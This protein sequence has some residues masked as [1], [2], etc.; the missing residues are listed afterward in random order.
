MHA[1]LAI[2]DVTLQRGPYSKPSPPAK[3]AFNDAH[4]IEHSCAT[5][6][7]LYYPEKVC[8]IIIGAGTVLH[9]LAIRLMIK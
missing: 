1:R 8:I 9:N 3:A 5:S 7:N 6:R 2:H 4:C